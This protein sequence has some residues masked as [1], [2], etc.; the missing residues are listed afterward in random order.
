MSLEKEKNDNGLNIEKMY[1]NSDGD[2][3]Y[4][5]ILMEWA[6]DNNID[7]AN[8]ARYIP[9]ATLEKVRMEYLKTDKLRPSIRKK[10]VTNTLF[11]I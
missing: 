10:Y 8:I 5:D 2:V 9:E 4:A 7:I 3:S 11:G 1:R 6:D